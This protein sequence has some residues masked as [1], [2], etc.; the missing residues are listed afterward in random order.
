MT[1]CFLR[2][3]RTL[4]REGVFESTKTLINPIL[5]GTS[6]TTVHHLSQAQA[7]DYQGKL[8]TI[9]PAKDTETH[10]IMKSFLQSKK[11]IRA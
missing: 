10:Q 5:S 4:I 9:P 8:V 2:G 3:V 1:L 7:S 6:P 11:Y